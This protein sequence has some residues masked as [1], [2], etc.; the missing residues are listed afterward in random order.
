MAADFLQRSRHKFLLEQEANQDFKSSSQGRGPAMSV[1]RRLCTSILDFVTALDE[2]SL[3]SCT[4]GKAAD[5][6]PTV[7]GE[8]GQHPGG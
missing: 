8:N 6:L 1:V 2:D 4:L 3:A 7:E 5:V